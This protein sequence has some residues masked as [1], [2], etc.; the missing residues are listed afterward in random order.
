MEAGECPG[1]QDLGITMRDP[2][3]KLMSVFCEQ[4]GG[5]HGE[6]F[7]CLASSLRNNYLAFTVREFSKMFKHDVR[8]ELMAH[9][10]PVKERCWNP[11]SWINALERLMGTKFASFDA[12]PANG[13]EG[14]RRGLTTARWEESE[15]LGSY[16]HRTKVL[17]GYCIPTL[18]LR[19]MLDTTNDPLTQ[20]LSHNEC[21]NICSA[22]FMHVA[23]T[24]QKVGSC[25]IFWAHVI[26]QFETEFP[27]LPRRGT[28]QKKW[29]A[30]LHNRF[31]NGRASNAT[32]MVRIRCRAPPRMPPRA[33]ATARDATAR[34]TATPRHTPA[35]LPF[36]CVSRRSRTR[37]Q[38]S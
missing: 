28:L 32:V 10:A 29:R 8:K 37:R 35:G 38:P 31:H 1:L 9:I 4:L 3:A 6:A 12:A 30:M 34:A 7:D 25:S 23:V 16:L 17:A 15:K 11:A 5:E 2:V 26:P 22:F 27:L 24:F 36:C 13:I 20:M 19:S 18:L 21:K 33:R 14:S